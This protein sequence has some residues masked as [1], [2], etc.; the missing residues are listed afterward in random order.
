MV[1]SR[2]I[3]A[4]NNVKLLFWEENL[5][6]DPEDLFVKMSRD[7]G[8]TPNR[9]FRIHPDGYHMV[10]FNSKLDAFIMFHY[11]KG[12]V[13]DVHLMRREEITD[14]DVALVV[15]SFTH[16]MLFYLWKA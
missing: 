14:E 10:F 11:I 8:F 6:I 7:P 1:P 5:A 12:Q 16:Y 13:V 3:F 15:E 2:S 9:K 4:D